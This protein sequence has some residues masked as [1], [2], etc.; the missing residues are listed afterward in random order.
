[1]ACKRAG[2]EGAKAN[3]QQALWMHRPRSDRTVIG[4]PLR[5]SI[6]ATPPSSLA[7]NIARPSPRSFAKL[8]RWHVDAALDIEEGLGIL[9]GLR[10]KLCLDLDPRPG[11]IEHR[12]RAR[13]GRIFRPQRPCARGTSASTSPPISGSSPAG[14]GSVSCASAGMQISLQTPYWTEAASVAG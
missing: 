4:R 11:P 14:R 7:M 3:A 5:A 9:E 6:S 8:G 12:N 10:R 1:M 2:G 13:N